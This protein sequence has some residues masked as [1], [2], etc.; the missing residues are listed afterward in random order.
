MSKLDWKPAPE[1][2]FVQLLRP[3]GGSHYEDPVVPP[4][5]HLRQRRS[6]VT[7]TPAERTQRG[8]DCCPTPS[9]SM[10]NSVLSLREASCSPSRRSQSK[11]ST[12]SERTRRSLRVRAGPS[13]SRWSSA[14]P[15]DEDDRRLQLPG[16]CKER[17]HQ[18]FAF[19]HLCRGRQ[20]RLPR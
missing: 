19:A 15:T 8:G 14:R 4:G 7:S 20:Q 10:R 18:L 11:L 6:G 2:G 16:H 12:S 17:S 13:V 3:V 5:L 9:N 1:D